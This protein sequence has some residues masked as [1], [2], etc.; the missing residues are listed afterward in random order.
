MR[1]LCKHFDIHLVVHIHYIQNMN[2]T[3]K[4]AVVTA[5]DVGWAGPSLRTVTATGSC[6]SG[7][8]TDDNDYPAVLT[9]G[10]HHRP[11][12]GFRTSARVRTFPTHQ[13]S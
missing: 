12:F 13:D 8:G 3:Q 2:E 11:Y 6:P 10:P 4:P 5:I 1:T 9:Q 7:A